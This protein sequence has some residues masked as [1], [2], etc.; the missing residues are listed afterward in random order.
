MNSLFDPMNILC[1]IAR[2]SDPQTSHDA[3]ANVTA[4][5]TR[6]AHCATILDAVKAHPDSTAGELAAI[7]GIDRVEV[8]RRL[9]DL[10]NA[11]LVWNPGVSRVCGE[12]G[13]RQMVWRA[14]QPAE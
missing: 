7:T 11:G 10:R 1:P 14:K 8:G 4:S 2:D 6:A 3:A 9:P 5:G 12:M 13:T